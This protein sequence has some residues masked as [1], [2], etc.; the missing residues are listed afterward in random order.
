MNSLDRSQPGQAAVVVAGAVPDRD[1]PSGQSM[2]AVRTED[3]APR[4]AP[5]RAARVYPFCRESSARQAARAEKSNELHGR[6]PQATRSH[7]RPTPAHQAAPAD[8]AH[9][10]SGESRQLQRAR[11]SRARRKP[12]S[13]SRWVR[14]VRAS[15][16]S[17]LRRANACRRRI[18]FASPSAELKSFRQHDLKA[19]SRDGRWTV[20]PGA[21]VSRWAPCAKAHGR[22]QGQL[23]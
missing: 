17:F 2:R 4:P 1:G 6:R 12:S 10:G 7:S 20:I 21:Y 5:D 14:L 13:V 18:A 23:P 9:R 22:G 3:P 11:Q 8:R 16:A 19:R 15:G